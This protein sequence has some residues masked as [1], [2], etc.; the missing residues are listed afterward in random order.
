MNRKEYALL[1]ARGIKMKR[2][3]ISGGNFVNK[4]AEAMLYVTANECF[5]RF[6]GC[7]CSV[8]LAEGF[9]EI[10]SL[11]DLNRLA[12]SSVKKMQSSG[13]IKKLIAMLE[14]YKRA[15][16]ML[17]ISGYELCS[18]LGNYPTLRYLFK[19]A[20]CK[21]TKTEAALMPQSF[22]PF[23]YD[24]KI[25]Y[26]IRLLIRKYLKYPLVCFAREKKSAEDLKK[27]APKANVQI[28]SDLVLQNSR[29]FEA[30]KDFFQDSNI[31]IKNESVGLVVNRRLYE[32][33]DH[34]RILSKYIVIVNT[35]LEKKKNVYLLCHATDD[36]NIC[37]EI[38]KEFNNEHRVVI[39]N[40]VLSCFAFESLVKNF[41][42]IVAARY[43]SIVHSYKECIP[44][45]A[46]GWAV[47]YQELLG[48]MGQS[49]YVLDVG[50]VSD[51]VIIETLERM[52]KNHKVEEETIRQN[53]NKVQKENC[54]DELE[55]RLRKKK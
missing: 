20:L 6:D 26:I 21:W 12:N 1:N 29:I 51:I 40:E 38:K 53:L 30:A 47:K 45:V 2:V 50:D 7:V 25:K 31:K 28:S 16:L 11:E 55:R 27:T 36:L 10:R 24:G 52:D 49:K 34:D 48:L 14:E 9:F 8:Q 35:I 18:K 17:D 4:G 15:D 44:C 43:H 22:G 46:L 39:L 19:I 3:I 37:N 32:Q 23:S 42:Y 5:T 54:F 41:D 33:Y 13:K